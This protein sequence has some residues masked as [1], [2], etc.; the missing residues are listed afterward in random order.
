MITKIPKPDGQKKFPEFFK[1]V[2]S[3]KPK[4]KTEKQITVRDLLKDEFLKP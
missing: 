2:F 4:P 1:E 3:E